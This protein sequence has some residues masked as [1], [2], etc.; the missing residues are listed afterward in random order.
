ME[1]LGDVLA[2]IFFLIWIPL[3]LLLIGGAIMIIIMNP[4]EMMQEAF[5]GSFGEM[6]RFGSGDMDQF[7][8]GGSDKFDLLER[9]MFDPG[10][11]V[12]SKEMMEPDGP[13][14]EFEDYIPL[15]R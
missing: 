1:K 2:I 3:G 13:T 8:P 15:T 10:A 4:L 5:S 14:A 7:G 11:G 12:L 9:D 6:D